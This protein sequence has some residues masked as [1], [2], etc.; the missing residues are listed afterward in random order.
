M[1][2][3]KL[4]IIFLI[5]FVNPVFGQT[6]IL[7]PHKGIEGIPIVIDS[8]E[9]SEVIKLY[10][11]DY[12]LT[13]KSSEN[14]YRYE[15]L[16]LTFETNPYDKN[17]I[18][19]SISVE[20]PFNAKTK[21]G[22]TL[23]ESTMRDVLDAFNSKGCFT[24]ESEAWSSQEGISFYIRKDPNEKGYDPNE[25]IYKIELNNNGKFGIPSTV[26]FEFNNQP[27]QSKL[28]SLIAILNSKNFDF[29]KLNEFWENE[30]L[31]ENETYG[32]EKRTAFTRVFENG[33]T[34]ESIE[35][36]IS[37]EHYEL[38]IIRSDDQLI[39][40]KLGESFEFNPPLVERLENQAFKNTDFEIYTFGTFC[41]FAGTPPFTCIDMLELVKSKNHKKLTEWL[42]SIN[43]EL[44]V[45]GYIGLN[46]LKRRGIKIQK[47]EL[48]RMNQLEQSEI[49]LN[50]CQGC[51]Y[52]VTE[53]IK[54]VLEKENLDGMYKSFKR[55]NWL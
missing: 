19:R 54:D 24:S 48:D 30:K 53:R 12:L 23:N 55:F 42:Y 50:T 11:N 46:F 51:L 25:K 41:G 22:I 29:E 16:G 9:I 52:G 18:V 28:D 37:S 32:L 2:L 40:L 47:N 1:K 34:Q 20:S 27:I 31:T 17:R 35:I 33:L 3:K 6:N 36:S 26:N 15:K 49:Q 45:Y 43:P 14:K 13:E 38:N 5:I 39:Y 44:S 8:T 4:Y 7:I 10:G 21:N